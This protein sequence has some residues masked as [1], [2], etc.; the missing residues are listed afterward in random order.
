EPFMHPR[1][2]DILDHAAR[3]GVKTGI[4][5]N[6]TYL[7]EEIAGRLEQVTVHQM[8][9]SLQT[10]DEESFKTRKARRMD[11]ELYKQKILEFI[12]ATLRQNNPPKIKMHFLNTTMQSEV[13][14]EDWSLGTMR[15]INNTRELRETFR[16][17]AEL[18]HQV[19]PPV[20]DSFR[21]KV[22]DKIAHLSAFKWNVVQVAPQIYFET[23]IL[24]TWGNA[25]VGDNVVPSTV[26]YC[27]ALTDH[28]AIQCNGNL[29]YCCKDYDGKTSAGNVFENPIVEV[30]NSQPIIDAV[31]GFK[32]FK[33]VHP[34]CQKCLGGSTWLKSFGNRVGSIIIWKFL[35]DFFY[36]KN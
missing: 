18:V 8:N 3:M 29:S 30:L 6:G 21:Q 36:K 16:T 2:F 31:E 34:H 17:W 22:Y 14:G 9:I 7:N 26:G 25:F 19:A 5:T 24:D 28:F 11:F 23:Y 20:D 27:S 4:T 10:P 15:V 33:V 1:F 35:K 12:A 32:K 13:P